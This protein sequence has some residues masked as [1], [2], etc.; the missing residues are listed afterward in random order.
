VEKN[1]QGGQAHKEVER[2]RR[3]RRRRYLDLVKCAALNAMRLRVYM[4]VE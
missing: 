4:Q 1:H 3:R 2:Q